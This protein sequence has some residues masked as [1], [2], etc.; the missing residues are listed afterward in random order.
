MCEVSDEYF[1]IGL[2]IF[3]HDFNV[4]KNDS[5][6]FIPNLKLNKYLNFFIVYILGT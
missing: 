2:N 5:P 1:I 6:F 4:L 3:I